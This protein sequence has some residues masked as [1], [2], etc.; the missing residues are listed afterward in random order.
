M[1]RWPQTPGS[2]PKVCRG[3]LWPGTCWLSTSQITRGCG[4]LCRRRLHT[5]DRRLRPR[6]QDIVDDLIDDMAAAAPGTAVGLI[7][8]FAFPLPFSDP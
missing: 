2:S 1:L 3:R 8:V 7:A 5:Q 4:S 6:M